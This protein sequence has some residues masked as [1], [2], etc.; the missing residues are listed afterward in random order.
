MQYEIKD[1]ST[2]VIYEVTDPP[3]RSKDERKKVGGDMV[4]CN[5]EGICRGVMWTPT[6]CKQE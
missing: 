6:E 3:Q 5:E 1:D 2:S 4:I